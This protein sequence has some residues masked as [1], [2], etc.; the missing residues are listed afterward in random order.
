MIYNKLVRDKIPEIIEASGATS[1]TRILAG[2]EYH[3]E[4]RRKLLEEAAE[5]ATS[6]GTTE[7]ADVLEVVYAMAEQAGLTREGLEQLRARKETERGAFAKKIYLIETN[8]EQA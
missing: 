4:L 6:D 5:A 2:A 1:E 7:L 3:E 8:K